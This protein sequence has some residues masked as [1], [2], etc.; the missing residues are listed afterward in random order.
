MKKVRNRKIDTIAFDITYVWNLKYDIN[1]CF[2]KA[3]T[4]SQ[5]QRIDL[6]LP[7][8]WGGGKEDWEFAITRCKLVHIGW[9]DY[10]IGNYTQYLMIN[11]TGNEYEKEH[12]HT[13]LCYTA[14]INTTL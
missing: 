10:S 9:I 8:G 13:H 7:R 4:D 11:H 6:C 1:E 2:Y 5:S 14:N 12:T 3:E